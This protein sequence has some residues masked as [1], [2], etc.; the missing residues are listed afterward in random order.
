MRWRFKRK[1]SW[2]RLR[3]VWN[4]DRII[5]WIYSYVDISPGPPASSNQRPNTSSHESLCVRKVWRCYRDAIVVGFLPLSWRDPS[6]HLREQ[7]V[8]YPSPWWHRICYSCMRGTR[9]RKIP[10]E[11]GIYIIPVRL[12]WSV[13]TT[14]PSSS[15][16]YDLVVWW[17]T[18]FFYILWK[19]YNHR[20]IIFMR[21]F[22][23]W[24]WRRLEIVDIWGSIA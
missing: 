1:L 11:L 19:L 16:A 10:D 24:I 2:L 5:T 17:P 7:I 8:R 15:I 13:C 12:S 9:W 18:L 4:H 6:C 23:C 20:Y 3:W 14:I 21:I 22:W